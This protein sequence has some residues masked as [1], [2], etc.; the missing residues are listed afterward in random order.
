VGMGLSNA[1]SLGFFAIILSP[2][3]LFGVNPATLA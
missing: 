2:P 3:P 1:Y